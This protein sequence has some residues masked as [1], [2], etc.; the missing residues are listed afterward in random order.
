MIHTARLQ[1]RPHIPADLDDSLRLWSEPDTVRYIGGR[2]LTKEDV[3]SRLLRNM[4][5]W[6]AL[7]F[8]YFVVR[9]AESF[10][11]E[12][13]V[14][15]FRRD[16]L[17]LPGEGEVGWV[18]HPDAHGQGYAREAVEAVLDWFARPTSCIIHPDN[19]ASLK[20]AARLHYQLYAETTYKGQP[21]LV[22]SRSSRR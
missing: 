10:L 22:F 14:A 17:D 7:G 6:Q 21:T 16:N 13:G 19:Q 15:D 5:H 2:P 3:W 1:L 4:G 11:G 18:F 12:V 20:L 8:G 9:Q